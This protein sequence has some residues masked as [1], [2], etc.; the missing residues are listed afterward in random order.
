MNNIKYINVNEELES[1][2][3]HVIKQS[4]ANLT[5]QGINSSKD[6]YKSLDYELTVSENSIDTDFIMEDYGD[7]IDKGVKGVE[8]G[9]SLSNYRYTNK[10]ERIRESFFI[11]S[12]CCKSK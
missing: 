2:W 12:Y 8:S 9:R 10:T 7:F 1:F 4:R 3:R 5:R 6:F 11:A